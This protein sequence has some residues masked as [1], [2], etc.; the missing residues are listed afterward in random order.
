MPAQPVESMTLGVYRDQAGG[1]ALWQETQNVDVDAGGT[2]SL[3]MGSTLND[4]IPVEL[5]NAGEPRWLS[6]QVNRA[7]EVEQ[8]RVL[9]ASVPYALKASDAETLGGRP[10]SAYLLAGTTSGGVASSSAEVAAHGAAPPSTTT[11]STIVGM[12]ATTALTPRATT[13]TAGFIGVFTDANDMGNSVIQQ[14][15]GNVGIGTVPGANAGTA[16]SLDL[17]TSPFSQIGMGQTVDY[18][19]F[20]SSDFYG[21]AIY[22]NPGKDLRLGRGGAGLYNAFGFTEQLRIQSATGNVGIGTQGPVAKLEVN[23]SVQ[24]DGNVTITTSGNGLIFP[25]GSKQTTAAGGGGG[26][27][28]ITGVTAGADLTGGGTS[29]N[30][31]LNLNTAL[32]P[33][34]GGSNAFTGSNTFGPVGA[35]SAAVN[36]NVTISTSG[37]GLIFPDGSKQ[38][39]AAGGGGGGSITGVTAGTDLTGGGTSGNVTLNLNTA[40]VP[41]LAGANTFAGSNTFGNINFSGS[42]LYQT[43]PLLQVPGGVAG[44]NI[45]LGITSLPSNTSGIYNTATGDYTLQ[46]NASGNYNTANGAYA[47]NGNNGGTSNTAVGVQTLGDNT[48][49]N[50]NTA[51]GVHAIEFNTTGTNNTASGYNALQGSLGI[52]TGSNNT[53]N[54]SGALQNNTTSGNNTA[55]GYQAL[56]SNTGDNANDN[57]AVGY[58]ALISNIGSMFG[59]DKNTAVGSNALRA[60]TG[61]GNTAI[62]YYAMSG[63]TTG[64]N[65]TVIGV[66][67]LV[68]A[69]NTSGSNNIAIGNS[70][71]FFVSNGSNNIHIGSVGASGDNS[72]IRIGDQGYQTAFVAGGIYGV[73]PGGVPVVINSSGQLG[74]PT[75]SR[76][77]KEDIQDMG[78]ASRGLMDLRPVTFRYKKAAE[79]G[80]KPLQYG[81]IAEEV[82]EVY[83]DLV[84]YTKDG[85]PDAVQY[86]NVNAMLLNEVQRQQAESTTQKEQIR[87]L[88]QMIKDQNE[89]FQQRLAKLEAALAS[90]SGVEKAS[91]VH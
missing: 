68:A 82:A 65:N 89:G 59:G 9:L 50:Y 60:N 81:L 61:F 83:P 88:E 72:T 78:D 48:T 49:G 35:T 12:A 62:G 79:D 8:P 20:F 13:G 15:N 28:S 47:L 63:N 54:G 39:T 66:N 58:Q 85:L 1:N 56:M 73:A 76:R 27:G 30:V 45:V 87:R 23:G 42:V 53:A 3:L 91:G 46:S 90:T 75:S 19:T 40:L 41:T 6:V 17:R 5:F 43:N 57:T 10:A 26:G 77:Y 2:Y 55:V 22:W 80:S 67:A 31:T 71:A 52:T 16:P 14:A 36:G 7:G 18:L 34:L 38:T 21:P 64:T 69:S 70:A 33:T 37:N 51:I 86:Q 4:G 11:A 24:A 84:V 32:V 44:G 29:G 25:D 74:A